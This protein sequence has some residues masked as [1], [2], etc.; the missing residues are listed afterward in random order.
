V[1]FWLLDRF[2]NGIRPPDSGFVT[3]S[4]TDWPESLRRGGNAVR[5]FK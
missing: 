2:F 1:G 4:A 5:R 3:S